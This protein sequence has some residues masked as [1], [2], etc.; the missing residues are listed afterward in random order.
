MKLWTEDRMKRQLIHVSQCH[1]SVEHTVRL[2][3]DNT[4]FGINVEIKSH[5]DACYLAIPSKAGELENC[6]LYDIHTPMLTVAEC[7]L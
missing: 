5:L 3:E 2:G 1:C 7:I 6:V 4:E